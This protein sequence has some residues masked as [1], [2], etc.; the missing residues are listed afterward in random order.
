MQVRCNANRGRDLPRKYLSLG[1]TEHSVF[2]VNVGSVYTVF[3]MSI[4]KDALH[5][6]LSDDNGLPNWHPIELFTV[7]D[8]RVPDDWLFCAYGDN[9]SDLKALWGYADLVRNDGHYD[10][11][12]EREGEALSLF[13]LEQ[14]RRSL[15]GESQ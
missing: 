10:A 11:L 3:G 12:L 1:Y 13:R 2:N 6:L 7:L 4:W 9:D 14:A 15:A 5:V 8:G